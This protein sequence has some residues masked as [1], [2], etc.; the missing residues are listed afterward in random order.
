MSTQPTKI[1][2][3]IGGGFSGAALAWHL[4]QKPHAPLK[5][6]VFEPRPT[7]GSGVAYSATDPNHR[8]NVPASRMSID[9]AHPLDFL[10]WL[11]KTGKSQHDPD[12]R[13]PDGHLYPA[14]K[15]FGQYVAARLAPLLEAQHLRHIPSVVTAARKTPKGKW[16][17]TT[18]AGDIFE[19][20]IVV[21]AT[22]HP[23]PRPPTELAALER[24]LSAATHPV[25]VTDPWKPDAFRTIKPADRVLIIG[26]GLSMAD[27]V[28]TLIARKHKAPL[29]AISRRGQRS[30]SHSRTPTTAIGDFLSPPASLT[31]TLLQKVRAAIAAHPDIPWQAFLDRVREQAPEI[32]SALNHTERQRLIRHLRPFWDTHR[33]RISPPTENFVDAA[34][35]SGQLR[36]QAARLIKVEIKGKHFSITLQHRNGHVEH[37]KVEAIITTTGPAHNSILNSQPVLKSLAADGHIE[38]DSSGLGLHVTT[39]GHAQVGPN[40]DSSLFIAG[41]LARGRFG[42]LMGLPEVTAYAEKLARTISTQADRSVLEDAASLS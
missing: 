31:K 28:A 42:E 24:T 20:D 12:A 38:M 29:L 26:T 7:L 13:Q 21:I 25:L 3:I 17:L 19:A 10:E 22:S 41:P 23:S 8:I 33:F 27:T 14:R 16:G 15:V 4:L 39:D 34:I 32:W 6:L 36:I 30:K 37:L 11:E 35:N 40:K 9:T 5:V 18:Q 1:I 2:A